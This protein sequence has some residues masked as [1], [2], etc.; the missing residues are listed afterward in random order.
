MENLIIRKTLDYGSR[1]ELLVVKEGKITTEIIE[2]Q[3]LRQIM[4][5]VKN[6]FYDLED[7]VIDEE[8]FSFKYGKYRV[9]FEFYRSYNFIRDNI[10]NLKN[11]KP[12]K[13]SILNK[14]DLIADFGNFK[15]KLKEYDSYLE[16][17]GILNG[18]RDQ[19]Q[20]IVFYIKG[21]NLFTDL[22]GIII[23]LVDYKKFSSDRKFRYVFEKI[24][25]Q[26]LKITKDIIIVGSLVLVS[27]I[28]VTSLIT[29]VNAEY[30]PVYEEP[31]TKIEE[32]ILAS[33]QL[34]D[35]TTN[36][37]TTYMDSEPETL[38]NI[39]ESKPTSEEQIETESKTY[40]EHDKYEELGIGSLSNNEKLLTAKSLY[41]DLIEKYASKYNVDPYLILAIA[42]QERG[43]HSSEIDKGGAIGLMQIQVDVWAGKSLNVFDYESN[44]EI[45]FNFDMER[46]KT[47]EGNIEAGCA[48]VQHYKGIMHGNNF[49]TIQSYNSGPYAVEDMV[50]KYKESSGKTSEEINLENDLG[51]YDYCTSAYKGD[52]EYLEHVLSYYTGDIRNLELNNGKLIS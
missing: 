35:K 16:I 5:Y 50:R 37:E 48:I 41:F 29:R 27:S 11:I 19:K 6:N 46:L 18:I 31:K 4:D 25:R 40:I 44:E 51:W 15:L 28:G 32:S 2:P 52:P 42:T 45:T 12:K 13:I 10:N 20:N 36:L 38:K 9:T 34:K 17:I 22:N 3:S 39:E 21:D 30:G 43:V 24:Q 14:H 33:L 49:T 26:K 8:N 47:V 23:E 7:P 1:G